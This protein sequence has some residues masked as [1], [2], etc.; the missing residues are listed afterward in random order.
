LDFVVFTHDPNP[1]HPWAWRL[2]LTN[3]QITWYKYAWVQIRR[4]S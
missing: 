1:S 3:P 4:A 2:A